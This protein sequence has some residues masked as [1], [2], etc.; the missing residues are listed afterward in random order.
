VSRWDGFIANVPSFPF[1]GTP[2]VVLMTRSSVKP[3]RPLVL[4]AISF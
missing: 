1:F 4:A 2:V 3:A